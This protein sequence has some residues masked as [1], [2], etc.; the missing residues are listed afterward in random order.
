MKIKEIAD[1]LHLSIS[2]VSKALNGGFDISK[3]T[4][5]RVLEYARTHGYKTREERLRTT[6]GRK[7]AILYD[8][9][10]VTSQTNIVIPLSLAIAR[11]AR[12]SNF[13]VLHIPCDSIQGDYTKYMEEHKY[14]AAFIAGINYKSQLFPKLKNTTIPTVLLDNIIENK[15][16]SSVS[17]ESV[18]SI[19]EL[20]AMLTKMG[21]KKIGFIHADKSSYVTNQR[22][23]GYIIGLTN[24]DI[25]FDPKYVY[26]GSYSE[27]SGKEA[28]H[29]YID[30]DVTAIICPSDIIAIGLM[31][32]LQ[33]L[34]KRIPE[35]YSITGYD[36]LD[37]AKYLR[38][39]LTTVRQ[40]TELMAE[41]IFSLITSMLM[42]RSSQTITIKSEIIKRESIGPA[43]KDDSNE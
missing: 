20:V 30:T 29:Y 28:A 17:S 31:H 2:T 18:N 13:D 15:N 33:N 37:F 9:N 22:F 12:E 39:S 26:F 38:P 25:E 3:E 10:T 4:K 34:G 6:F 8:N 5:D 41:K 11:Y 35:D 14:V 1:E 42:N 16:I 27:E 36:D 21:H 43:R 23:A 7:L 19:S 24:N 40:N 32:E